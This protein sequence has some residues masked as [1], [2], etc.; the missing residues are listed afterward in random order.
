MKSTQ[1]TRQVTPQAN[2]KGKTMTLETT[3]KPDNTCL[4]VCAWCGNTVVKKNAYYNHREQPICW[5]CLAI[6]TFN[7]QATR[8]RDD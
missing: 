5:L 2:K 1:P 8:T 4:R 3:S 6:A 7:G